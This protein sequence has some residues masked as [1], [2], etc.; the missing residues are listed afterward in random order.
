M[1]TIS[2]TVVTLTGSAALRMMSSFSRIPLGFRRV[3]IVGR[4]R[5]AGLLQLEAAMATATVS[6]GQRAARPVGPLLALKGHPLEP[7]A[8]GRRDVGR[9][10]PV[11]HTQPVRAPRAHVGSGLI[12][13][14]DGYGSTAITVRRPLPGCEPAEL[15]GESWASCCIR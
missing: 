12:V 13:D 10:P 14:G 1:M 9:E 3:G 7:A 4:K 11:L 2:S 15:E 5:P 8:G 6:A